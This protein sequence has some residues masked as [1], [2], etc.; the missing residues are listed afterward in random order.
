MRK[1]LGFIALTAGAAFSFSGI[2]HAQPRSEEA[3]A[4][5]PWRIELMMKGNKFDNCS[6]MRKVEDINVTVLRA[7]DGHTMV[8]DS[9][10]WK[11]DRGKQYPVELVAGTGKWSARASA[12]RDAVSIPLTDATFIDAL[13]KADALEVRGDGA[14][15]LIALDRSAAAFERLEACFEKNSASIETNPFV[16][17]SR[18][19]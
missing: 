11:L 1:T 5:G 4:V 19:P 14:T 7:S 10:K 15:I 16:A 13:R 8:L 2:A 17:P 9:A 3:V 18:K 6:M 12:Q